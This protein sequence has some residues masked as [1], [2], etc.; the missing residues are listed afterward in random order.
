M[1]LALGVGDDDIKR[2][3]VCHEFGHALGLGH[4]HQ[5]PLAPELDKDK[6]INYLVGKC[7]MKKDAAE[8]KYEVDYKMD[9]PSSD[10]RTTP[11]D[12]RSIMQYP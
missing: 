3:L 1:L 11:H 7:G 12:P 10:S 4:E 2:Y 8:K 9:L 6:V 5:S